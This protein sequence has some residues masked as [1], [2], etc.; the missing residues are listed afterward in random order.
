MRF[1]LQKKFIHIHPTNSISTDTGLTFN[2][3]QAKLR[4]ANEQQSMT[5]QFHMLTKNNA[6]NDYSQHVMICITLYL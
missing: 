6:N 5:L 1:C 2:K 4:T 3:H